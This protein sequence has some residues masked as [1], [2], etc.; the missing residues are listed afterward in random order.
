MNHRYCVWFVTPDDDVLRRAEIALD[1]T[2]HCHDILEGIEEQLAIDCGLTQ[3][4]IV[5]WK[6]FEVPEPEAVPACPP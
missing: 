5:D 6:R 3:V 4:V 1:N 2:I